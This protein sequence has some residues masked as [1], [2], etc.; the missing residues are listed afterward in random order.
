MPF[1]SARSLPCLVAG[2]IAA[3]GRRRARAAQ[4]YY[5][6]R[7]IEFIVGGDSGGGYDIYA[8]AVA[9]HLARH[10]PGNPNIVVKNMPGAGSTRAGIY[11]STVA[12]KD[13]G[14]VGALMP[15]AIVGPL[16]EDKPMTQFDPTKVI[17]IGTAD[18]GVRVCATYQNSKINTLRR[19]AEGQDHSRRQLRRRRDPR[20]RLSAQSHRRHQVQ[21]RRRLQGHGR[22]RA[23]DGARRGRRAVRLG[24]VEREVAERRV[25]QGQEAQH[26][27]AGRPR[28]AAGADRHGRPDDLD[29]RQERER[30]PRRRAGRQPAGVP[31][32]LHRSARH[33]GGAGQD[34]AHGV[35]RDDEGSAVPR[36]RGQDEDLDHAAVGPAG[37]GHRERSSTPRRARLVE[38]A[39]GRRSS[40][41]GAW[42]AI[43]HLQP[44]LADQRAPQL[45]LARHVGGV[46]LRRRRHRIAALL[47]E[48]VEHVGRSRRSCA[49]PR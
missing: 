1:V 44:E 35:R 28:S 7:T 15:G 3:A 27:G 16:L 31:A 8:R 2:A 13:G 48:T 43:S 38:R 37:A 46:F 14:S 41:R 4:D 36:R 30:P 26:P 32:L 11:I 39:R 9:R 29:L 34:P 23:R 24:L 10:I 22:H 20:L 17:Y 6:G 49:A 33:A 40:R 45:V 21:R 5:A 18:T 12:P 47:G 25:D 42:S 19:R